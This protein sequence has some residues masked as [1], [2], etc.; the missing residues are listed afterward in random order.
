[1]LQVEL[2]SAFVAQF[3]QTKISS[4]TSVETTGFQSASI[5]AGAVI[6][7]AFADD[8]ATTDYDTAVTVVK[9]GQ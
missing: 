4:R 5:E 7:V 9:G 3:P 6:V 2:V 1:M 8:L